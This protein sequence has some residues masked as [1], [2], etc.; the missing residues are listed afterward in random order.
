MKEGMLMSTDNERHASA[1]RFLLHGAALRA[2]EPPWGQLRWLDV[3]QGAPLV[4]STSAR[5]LDLLLKASPGVLEPWDIDGSHLEVAPAEERAWTPA[6]R[7]YN[8][9][10]TVRAAMSAAH[11]AL[12]HCSSCGARF[13]ESAQ[14]PSSRGALVQ[15]L[16]IQVALLVLELEDA[17]NLT[18]D[19]V[20]QVLTRLID[21]DC[22]AGAQEL[23]KG[24]LVELVRDAVIHPVK[25][26][27]GRPL[28]TDL[29]GG[30]SA[31]LFSI[32][33]FYEAS[34]WPA[35]LRTVR[36]LPTEARAEDD[37][38]WLVALY[39]A[40][41]RFI[42]AIV[43]IEFASSAWSDGPPAPPAP[44]TSVHTD[45]VRRAQAQA[46]ELLASAGARPSESGSDPVDVSFAW[47][48]PEH[49]FDFAGEEPAVADEHQYGA[50][51]RSPS[52]REPAE[53]EDAESRSEAEDRPGAETPPAPSTDGRREPSESEHAAPRSRPLAGAVK[54]SPSLEVA[55]THALAHPADTYR[56]DHGLPSVSAR[57]AFGRG[58]QLVVSEISA[59]SIAGQDASVSITVSQD[60]PAALPSA[61]TTHGG[62]LAS[63]TEEDLA[64]E[65]RV[66]I[67]VKPSYSPPMVRTNASGRERVLEP[68]MVID[69]D[70]DEDVDAAGL[71]VTVQ[72]LLEQVLAGLT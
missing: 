38:P 59:V 28:V 72:A 68:L 3:V 31:R 53:E 51:G 21:A 24:F 11:G 5:L 39:W 9:P 64:L 37:A 48:R 57:G 1:R 34:E 63:I 44:G 2:G 12:G 45:A 71:R 7:R 30:S 62:E 61:R 16:K 25:R 26:P 42:V 33:K 27:R 46:R 41:P 65:S 47:G 22:E 17:L 36:E 56:A 70:V 4:L 6:P 60:R 13:Q 52:G 58:T 40:D 54:S 66:Q 8:D 20:W 32:D 55:Y 69:I 23:T 19:Q 14:S 49:W 43:P 29:A 35:V 15:A 50:G 18:T 67:S 10:V